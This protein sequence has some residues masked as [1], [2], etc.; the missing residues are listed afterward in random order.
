ML[1]TEDY[2]GAITLLH[3]EVRKGLA[4]QELA[5]EYL[6][7]ANGTIA[8]AQALTRE[9]RYAEA[10]RLYRVIQE[11]GPGSSGLQR[12]LSVPPGRMEEAIALCAEN[13]MEA[14]LL[15]YRAGD[16]TAAI[17]IWQQVL[18]FSPQH[19]AAQSSIQTTQLQRANLKNLERKN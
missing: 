14:G 13:I 16:F 15:A 5:R 17:T 19:P 1:K 4:E 8:Q 7:A 3:L 11:R 6:Q 10:A 18:T 2:V 12:Q 9:G